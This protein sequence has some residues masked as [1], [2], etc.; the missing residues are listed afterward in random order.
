[1]SDGSLLFTARSC[2]I[3]PASNE[4]TF[5]AAC[6]PASVRPA[7]RRSAPP[8]AADTAA[9]TVGTSGCGAQPLYA[10]PS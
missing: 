1:M 9:D 5:A 10:V 2:S 7:T 6:T 8:T 4:T 3:R